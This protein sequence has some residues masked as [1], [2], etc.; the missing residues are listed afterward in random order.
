M[1]LQILTISTAQLTARSLFSA[2]SINMS[3]GQELL[4][5]ASEDAGLLV[6]EQTR[7]LELTSL[8]EDATD[9]ETKSE[10]AA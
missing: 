9:S 10:T 5:R 7:Y 3:R 2:A 4:T 1:S 8:M 6:L